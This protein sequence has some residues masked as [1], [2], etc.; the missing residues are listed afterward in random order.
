MPDNNTPANITDKRRAGV[1]L[2]ITSLPGEDDQGDMGH[3]AYRFIEFLSSA[4]ISIWQTLPLGPVHDDR[5]PYQCLS[6]HA[7]NP[8]LI[9]QDWLKDRGWLDKSPSPA[10][11]RENW[12]R[13]AYEGFKLQDDH[14]T[15]SELKQFCEQEKHWLDDYALYSALRE[16]HKHRPW[17][18]WP[19][20]IRDRRAN[21]LAKAA[22]QL[23]DE[24]DRIRFEQFVFF[25]QWH[26]LRDF[27]HRHNVYLFGDMPIFVAHDSAEVWAHREYFSVTSDGQASK[28]AGVPPDYFSE[29]GQRWGNPLYNW[30]ALQKDDFQWWK[31]RL[32]S[33][34]ALF[35]LIRIDHFRGLEAYWEIPAEAETAI[36]GH[37]V[38]APGDALLQA[39]T[40]DLHGL[41][42]VAE[43][44]G[45]ITAEVDALRHKYNIPGMKII[46]FAFDGDPKNPYLPHQHQSDYVVYTGTHDND[47]TLAWFESLDDHAR[48]H[49]LDYLGHPTEAFPWPLIRVALASVANIAILPM[50]DILALGAN[51]RMNT[52]GTTEGNWGWR[53]TW[54]QVPDGLGARLH[55]LLGLYNRL[56]Q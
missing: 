7:G 9:S 51:N 36:H 35:D 5:S 26:E 11:K 41:P 34:L 27:A 45:T 47:C 54:E 32:H 52:P 10:D 1:L 31:Q 50:Q 43:D 29:T 15:V 2:H 53:F 40:E 23:T 8:L 19:V 56:N 16:Q 37:W 17:M 39:L 49:V 38:K 33:Q 13:L 28:I 18:E 42:L 21:S 4:G 20:S 12:L 25:K 3:Q 48:Q 46:Q 6:V 24:I 55:H 44:L 14:A 22:Q 30:E